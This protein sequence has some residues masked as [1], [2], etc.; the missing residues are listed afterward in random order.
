MAEPC[1]TVFHAW[2]CRGQWQSLSQILKG[3]SKYWD[4]CR[5]TPSYFSFIIFIDTQIK[6]DSPLESTL[7]LQQATDTEAFIL[8][9]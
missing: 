1:H 3:L 2:K 8:N 5:I 4:E 6:R 7:D 9:F